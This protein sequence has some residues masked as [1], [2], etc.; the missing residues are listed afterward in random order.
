M[1]KA[2]NLYNSFKKSGIDFFTGVPDS[3]LKN[4]CGYITDSSS[5]KEHIIASNE[6]SALALATGY[7]LSTSKIP[8]VYLQNS[9]LGNLVNPLL[10]LADKEVYG[11]PMLLMIGWRGE[12]GKKDEPQHIKQGR[13]QNS[14]LEAMEIPYEILDSES[15]DLDSLIAALIKKSI[16]LSSPVALV[17]RKGTF[18][19]YTLKKEIP[20]NFELNR[21]DAVSEIL[22]NTTEND[23]IVSTTG[24]TSREVFEWRA[25]NNSGHR[26][27]FLTVGS[28]GHA[29]Q[30]ALGIALNTERTVI[31]LDGDGA[32]L[33]HLGSV[34]T[35]GNSKAR[36][37]I[38]IVINNGVHDSVGGQPTIALDI[39]IT[40]IAKACG[41][42]NVA[43][44]SKKNE[45]TS[46]LNKFKHFEGPCLIEIRTKQG[47]RNDLGRPTKSPKENKIALMKTLSK[48]D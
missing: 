44:V 45:I 35:I 7:Y 37:F 30:I 11:I 21:E 40:M 24:K 9:G 33:M 39:D 47:A 3:L 20:S 26:N 41:Y 15:T 2:S 13:V 17:V 1:I 19:P 6:G 23:I 10:S 18:E 28:M 22:R 34:A 32:L 46:I 4:I 14:L 27:D 5:E 8:L 12:P 43:S 31:C 48:N 42:K 38:H 16:S 25:N 29:N 36:H